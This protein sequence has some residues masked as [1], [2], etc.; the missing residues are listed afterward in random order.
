MK[1]SKFIPCGM[2]AFLV[3]ASVYATQTTS[4]QIQLG[5]PSGAISNSA[6]RNNY[7]LQSAQYALDYS[8]NNGEPNWVSWDLTASDI[9]SS[10]RTSSFFVDTRLPAS[11]FDVAHSTYTG[12]GFDRGHMCPSADRTDTLAHN[13]VL[14]FMSNIIPQTADN[15]QGPWARFEAFCRTLSQSGFEV[16]IT[17]GP[18]T[19]SGRDI[20][21][22]PVAIPGYT[23]KIAVV[24]PS[25]GGTAVSRITTATRVIAVRMPNIAGIRSNPWQN[26]L[27][28]TNAI[29][30][31]TGYTFFRTLPSSVATALRA[32]VDSGR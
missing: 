28:S 18:S 17:S 20:S 6:N 15:N 8:D 3:A 13:R 4:L 10:G 12:S 31:A 14:F 21:S 11:F 26:Y 29:Q 19:F 22:G 5:N 1:I 24:V 16:L 9:G 23:W 7:L 2:L 27:T 32:K 25:G 30:S